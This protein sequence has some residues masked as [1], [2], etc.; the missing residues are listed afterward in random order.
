MGETWDNRQQFIDQDGIDKLDKPINTVFNFI[1]SATH[2]FCEVG[3]ENP[4]NDSFFGEGEELKPVLQ[5][6]LASPKQAGWKEDERKR[7]HKCC[8]R[9]HNKHIDEIYNTSIVIDG[10]RPLGRK[11]WYYAICIALALV[12]C[13]SKATL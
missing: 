10:Q 2:N 8:I 5:P 13:L 6:P 3:S 1:P 12:F 11:P 7:W 4:K 9:I